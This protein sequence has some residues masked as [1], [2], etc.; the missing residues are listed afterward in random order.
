MDSPV[1][2]FA[3]W[4]YWESPALPVAWLQEGYSDKSLFD[5]GYVELLRA[6]RI[7]NALWVL[8]WYSLTGYAA[9]VDR[10]ATSLTGYLGEVGLA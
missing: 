8:R 3:K 6:F 10:A 2:E 5:D 9:G 4:D 7:A 1:N